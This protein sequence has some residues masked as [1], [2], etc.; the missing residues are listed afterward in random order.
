MSALQAC[1]DGGLV[2]LHN[3]QALPP[4]VL[5]A[6]LPLLSEAGQYTHHGQPVPAWRATVVLTAEVAGLGGCA[7]AAQCQRL[8]KAGVQSLLAG[9]GGAPDDEAVA[10]LAAAFR[11]RIDDVAL[12]RMAA[13][14]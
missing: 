6:L 4:G 12:L 13:V 2:V 9:A 7:P 5:P 11:R 8:A 14:S 10:Q 1:P 3:L